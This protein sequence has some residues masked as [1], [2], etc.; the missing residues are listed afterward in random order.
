M[1]PKYDQSLD[2]FLPSS[3]ERH[4]LLLFELPCSVGDNDLIST[5]DTVANILINKGNKNVPGSAYASQ[6]APCWEI[7]ISET[8]ISILL[9]LCGVPIKWDYIQAAM[10]YSAWPCM[11][12]LTPGRFIS[13]SRGRDIDTNYDH[14]RKVRKWSFLRRE[15]ERGTVGVKISLRQNFVFPKGG[16]GS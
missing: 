8:C 4:F 5:N 14:G 7:V 6:Q 10:K 1:P 2:C 15:M 9:F 16:Q 3:S 11:W 12:Y 13:Y